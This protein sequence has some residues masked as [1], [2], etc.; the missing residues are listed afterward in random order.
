MNDDGRAATAP[1]DERAAGAAAA[2]PGTGTLWLAGLFMS[3]LTVWPL[4]VENELQL[5]LR[6]EL[7]EEVPLRGG[8]VQPGWVSGVC[9]GWHCVLPRSG[10]ISACGLRALFSALA[11]MKPIMAGTKTDV[12]LNVAGRHCA[13]PYCAS[14]SDCEVNFGAV[15]TC[16]CVASA[17]SRWQSAWP[18]E[19]GAGPPDGGS[20]APQP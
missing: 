20:G 19:S 2:E 3:R 4:A 11:T 16:F 9:P 12:P 1:R 13:L 17:K 14:Q 10:G 6:P 8:A 5:E 7:P 15:W 18:A